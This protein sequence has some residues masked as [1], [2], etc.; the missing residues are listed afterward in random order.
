[1]LHS[2]C[3][4]ILDWYRRSVL[5]DESRDVSNAEIEESW[6]EEVDLLDDDASSTVE[7]YWRRRAEIED[8]R[9]RFAWRLRRCGE[10]PRAAL[11][12]L[13]SLPTPSGSPLSRHQGRALTEAAARLGNEWARRELKQARV[14]KL[15]VSPEVVELLRREV[16]EMY[17]DEEKLII[18]GP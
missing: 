11:A 9:F 17:K 10:V 13:D 5:A 15:V 12:W 3:A 8:D 16:E 2:A 4:E 6:R 7:E 18:I 1:M 14:G